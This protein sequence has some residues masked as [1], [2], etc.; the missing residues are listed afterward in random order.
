M[1]Q[2]MEQI[3]TLETQL[4]PNLLDPKNL[5]IKDRIH[6][7]KMKVNGTKPRNTEVSCVGCSG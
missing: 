7:L 3:A 1:E 5:E 2:I 6:S 4:T